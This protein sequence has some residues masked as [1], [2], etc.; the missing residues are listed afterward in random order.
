MKKKKIVGVLCLVTGLALAACGGSGDGNDGSRTEQ[1]V[2]YEADRSGGGEAEQSAAGES[3]MV[4]EIAEVSNGAGDEPSIKNH[5]GMSD[6]EW[7]KYLK[8]DDFW[9]PY[10]KEHSVAYNQATSDDIK[11]LPAD[12]LKDGLVLDVLRGNEDWQLTP[13]SVERLS[14][15]LEPK[16]STSKPSEQ[17]LF[18]YQKYYAVNVVIYNNG[19]S[20]MTYKECIENG[21]YYLSG[22][23]Y[24]VM[25]DNTPVNDDQYEN[26]LDEI[27]T[28]LGQPN[29]ILVTDS[30]YAGQKK[31]K[32][33]HYFEDGQ[34]EVNF[35]YVYEFEGQRLVLAIL[36]RIF[37]DEDFNVTKIEYQNGS[38][39]REFYCPS[40]FDFQKNYVLDVIR[41]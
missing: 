39:F 33:C 13:D 32:S 14:D 22:F 16:H 3:K 7:K 31:L 37:F 26:L 12:F 28:R 38:E 23:F 10:I 29:Q 6:E 1:Q 40:N 24:G 2:S 35:S 4:E 20:T 8:T 15:T 18:Q 19:E 11:T 5:F 17:L 9:V 21:W 41:L 27:L 36:E 30:T 34:I 25:Q